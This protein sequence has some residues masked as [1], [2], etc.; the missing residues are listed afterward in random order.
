MICIIKYLYFTAGLKFYHKLTSFNNTAN[1][2][3]LQR[4][5]FVKAVNPKFRQ[6]LVLIWGTAEPSD[7][8]KND[9]WPLCC[10]RQNHLAWHLS[11]ESDVRCLLA[12][13][14]LLLRARS[15]GGCKDLSDRVSGNDKFFESILPWSFLNASWNCYY[16]I[17]DYLLYYQFAST[18]VLKCPVS[19]H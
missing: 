18:C 3:S 6:I 8:H 15:S 16:L 2:V 4:Q 1:I 13:T 10:I 7:P 9:C 5:E 14:I 17:I 19:Y 11:L 12:T